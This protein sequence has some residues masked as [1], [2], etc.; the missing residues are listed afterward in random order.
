MEIFIF[1]G[2]L[3]LGADFQNRDFFL[4]RLRF[5]YIYIYLLLLK[6]YSHKLYPTYKA[7]R[8]ALY[9]IDLYCVNTNLPE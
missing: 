2:S 1:L 3:L 6:C 7:F 9:R 4:S 8:N 5:I